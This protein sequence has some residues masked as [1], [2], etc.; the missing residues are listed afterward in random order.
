M[1]NELFTIFSSACLCFIF[2]FPDI[3]YFL[4]PGKFKGLTITLWLKLQVDGFRIQCT[5]ISAGPFSYCL[6]FLF[7]FYTVNETYFRG[8]NILGLKGTS[9]AIVPHYFYLIKLHHS[10]TIC[11][12]FISLLSTMGILSKVFSITIIVFQL[13]I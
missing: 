10:N 7:Q 12:G 8:K 3:R 1:A 5:L 2:V 13:R 4:M 6:S 11:N 9:N